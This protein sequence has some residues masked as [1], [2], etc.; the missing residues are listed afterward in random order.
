[1]EFAFYLTLIVAIIVGLLRA[2]TVRNEMRENTAEYIIKKNK[3]K[4]L[5]NEYEGDYRNEDD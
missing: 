1:M 5:Y 4:P 3:D 2:I